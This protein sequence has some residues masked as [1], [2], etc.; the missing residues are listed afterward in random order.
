MKT[1]ET[2]HD[3][4]NELPEERMEIARRWLENLRD[5]ALLDGP[6][7]FSTRLTVGSQRSRQAALR[8]S[9]SMS[10]NADCDV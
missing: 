2:L 9:L 5:A 10:A 4:S 7:R 8:A 3:L 1:R 6:P